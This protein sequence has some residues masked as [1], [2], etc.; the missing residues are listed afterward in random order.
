MIRIHIY[1]GEIYTYTHY[2]IYIYS[3]MIKI[4][5]IDERDHINTHFLQNL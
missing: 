2:T 4:A 5:V 1:I 3:S